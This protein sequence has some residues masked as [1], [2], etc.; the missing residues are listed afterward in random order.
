M[1]EGWTL[2]EVQ[3]R[4]RDGCLLAPPGSL[5]G[6]WE[7]R[8][9][10]IR[11]PWQVPPEVVINERERAREV[12]D[13]IT[14]QQQQ[15]PLVVYTDGSGYQG[16]A[17]VVPAFKTCATC[18][19]GTEETST[20]YAAE[21]REID[22][23]LGIIKRC[24]AI[25]RWNQ[26]I[27]N[28]V[29][30]FSDS[31]ASLKA[32]TKPRMVSGQVF[33]QKCLETI[34]WCNGRGISITFQWIPAHEGVPGNEEADRMAKIAAIRNPQDPGGYAYTNDDQRYQQDNDNSPVWLMAVARR[35]IRRRAQETWER[36]WEKEGTGRPTKRLIQVPG[37]KVLRYWKGLRKATSS[38]LMQLRTG[39]IGLNQYLS[40]IN[41]RENARCEYE[42]GNQTPRHVVTECPLLSELRA[43]MWRTLRNRVSRAIDFNDLLTEP[44]AAPALADFMI[45]TGLLGQ[46]QAVDSEATGVTKEYEYTDQDD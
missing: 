25:P 5:A 21:L 42:L 43:D 16:N 8:C 20:V 44:K 35:R 17:A 30:V 37:K 9:A 40:R 28:G 27:Q 24:H 22:M 14:Q 19:L 33:L 10:F 26:Q 45:Q 7:S 36:A 1:L 11:A 41:I 39:R 12:H 6:A 29:V 4:K 18:Q 38:V 13:K 32:L 23:A 15:A 31:Q 34:D 2:L 3:A 46:F